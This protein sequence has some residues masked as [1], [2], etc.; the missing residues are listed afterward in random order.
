MMDVLQRIVRL[1]TGSVGFI[2][3]QN[4]NISVNL[5]PAS[6]QSRMSSDSETS[7]VTLVV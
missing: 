1:K 2:K 4:H 3:A 5:L 6:N 7:V